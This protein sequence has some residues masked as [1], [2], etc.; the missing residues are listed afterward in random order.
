MLF[1]NEQRGPAYFKIN[2]SHLLQ[3]EYQEQIKNT[4]SETA[5]NNVNANP[6]VSW[7]V[8]KGA[9]RNTAIQYASKMKKKENREHELKLIVDMNNIERDIHKPYNGR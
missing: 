8:I 2:N 3:S 9:M 4:I 5:T 7:E 6:N 1:T